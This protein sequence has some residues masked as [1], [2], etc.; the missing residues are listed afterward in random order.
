MTQRKCYDQTNN[1]FCDSWKRLIGK[2]TEAKPLHVKSLNYIIKLCTNP[3]AK[4]YFKKMFNTQPEP[5][6]E[7][8]HLKYIIRFQANLGKLIHKK[9]LLITYTEP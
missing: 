2:I 6:S 1:G 4:T 9:N 7:H 3:S 8:E 5:K